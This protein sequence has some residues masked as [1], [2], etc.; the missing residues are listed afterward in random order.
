ML[1]LYI[2]CLI[3]GGALLAF[4]LL[5]GGDGDHGADHSI[6]AHHDFDGAH[7][8]DADAHG[9]VHLH[10]GEGGDHVDLHADHE[11][12]AHDDAQ[13]QVEHSD[14]AEFVKFF[15]F[16]NMIYFLAFFGLTGV[17]MELLDT[18]ASFAFVSSILMG[19][20]AW[21]FGYRFMKY[22][23]SSESG[24]S[25]NVF[26]LRGK[27]AKVSLRIG[28]KKQGKI[29]VAT[30]DNTLEMFAKISDA[31]DYEE[32]KSGEDVL[33]IEVKNNLAYVVKADF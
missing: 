31:S 33:I 30:G 19:G 28:R 14:P 27:T 26:N 17:A 24:Q 1:T 6:D 4:S 2:V 23:K 15:S 9:E 5:A 13:I 11:I 22:L 29:I 10:A 12:A 20:F 18:A 16:R 7:H 32:F 21:V 25:V 8:F 3:L